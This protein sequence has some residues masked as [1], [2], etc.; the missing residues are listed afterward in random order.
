[1]EAAAVAGV[2]SSYLP[3]PTWG[4]QEQGALAPKWPGRLVAPRV[5]PRQEA[6]EASVELGASVCQL[7][8][9]VVAEAEAQAEAGAGTAKRVAQLTDSPQRRTQVAAAVVAPAATRRPSQSCLAV[10]GVSADPDP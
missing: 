3:A 8:A 4:R 6:R 1:L 10:L 5:S 7:W 9:P 2:A